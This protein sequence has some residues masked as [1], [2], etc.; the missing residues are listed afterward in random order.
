MGPSVT[1]PQRPKESTPVAAENEMNW[2][3]KDIPGIS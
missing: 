2:A 1:M 3:L